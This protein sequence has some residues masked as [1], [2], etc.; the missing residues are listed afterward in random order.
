M[1]QPSNQPSS[2]DAVPFDPTYADIVGV[3]GVLALKQHAIGQSGAHH[4]DWLFFVAIHQV[5]ELWFMMLLHELE[6]ARDAIDADDP[7]EASVRMRRVKSIEEIL[8]AQIDTLETLTAGQFAQ[9]RPYL[10]S[11]SGFQS[12]QFREIE[13]LSGLKDDSHLRRTDITAAERARLER[14]LAEPTVAERFD[15]FVERHPSIDLLDATRTGRPGELV[16]L[17]EALLDHDEMMAVWRQRHA[18]IVERTIGF[19]HG[20]GGTD[21]VNFLTR[22]IHR[23]FFPR[24]WELRSQI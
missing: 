24:L 10:G 18:L 6:L 7:L 9:I 8:I 12:V 20:T 23:W 22:R 4:P 3:E 15:A 14:R 19:K 17:I 21:G 5:Y 16:G 1:Q 2:A 13:F 11:A